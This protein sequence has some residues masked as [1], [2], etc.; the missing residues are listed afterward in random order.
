MSDEELILKLL[1]LKHSIEWEYSL[2]YVIA[3][4]EAIRRLNEKRQGKSADGQE[5]GVDG[6]ANR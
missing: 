6:E 1:V 4:D 2:E 3:L 5:A